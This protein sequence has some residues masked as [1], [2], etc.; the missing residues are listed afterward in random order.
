MLI[1]MKKNV[2]E[3]ELRSV[4]EYLV[5]RDFDFHQ[6]T[7]TNRVIIGV[8]GDATQITAEELKAL[9]GVLEVFRIP[10]ED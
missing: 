1:I 10:S 5:N 8:I 2:A 7:G 3:D 6:S 9:A 4:K